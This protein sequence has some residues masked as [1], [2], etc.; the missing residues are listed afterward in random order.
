MDK[1]FWFPFVVFLTSLFLAC[2]IR[3]QPIDGKVVSNFNASIA[4][5]T[6]ICEWLSGSWQLHIAQKSEQIKLCDSLPCEGE[7]FPTP[8][9]FECVGGEIRG[10]LLE[11]V[12]K[13]EPVYSA[14]DT[15]FSD[16]KINISNSNGNCKVNYSLQIDGEILIGT[17][18]ADCRRQTMFPRSAGHVVVIRTKKE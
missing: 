15:T 2:C 4:T 14:L 16:G 1:V 17:Y 6:E 7:S 10:K 5:Q 11:I 3:F 13:G 8:I 18:E 9:Y 12:S